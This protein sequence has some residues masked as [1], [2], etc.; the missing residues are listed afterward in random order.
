MVKAKTPDEIIADVMKSTMKKGSEDKLKEISKAKAKSGLTG[1]LVLIPLAFLFGWLIQ[2]LW[3]WLFPVLFNLPVITY[4][5]GIGLFILGRF[6]F[7]K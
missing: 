7:G 2:L 5:Q 6:F 4:W 3:N 1:I